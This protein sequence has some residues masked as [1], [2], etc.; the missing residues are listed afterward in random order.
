MNTLTLIVVGLV[1]FGMM[2]GYVKV[3][4][5]SV[6]N[7]II[8]VFAIVQALFLG[9]MLCDF[10]MDVSHLDNIIE[11]KL[12]EI[13]QGDIEEKVSR[14]YWLKTGVDTEDISPRKLEKL[15]SNAYYVDPTQGVRANILRY[16]GFPDSITDQMVA[17]VDKHDDSYIPQD[18]YDNFAE[19]IAVFLVGRFY[20]LFSGLIIF[21]MISIPIQMF[22]KYSD[23]GKSSRVLLVAYTNKI[24]G[25][26]LGGFTALI[27]VWSAI[28]M[29]KA[30]PSNISTQVEKQIDE[31]VVLSTIE[32]NNVVELFYNKIT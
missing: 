5:R 7:V 3:F 13:V 24:G 20:L 1:I 18:E 29:L 15:V 31:S 28:F 22:V 14:D 10:I 2:V 25:A 32:E 19:Y 17:L 16:A 11:R 8:A 12:G 4:A 26:I 6:I 21:M 30:V 23:E 27:I 9:P